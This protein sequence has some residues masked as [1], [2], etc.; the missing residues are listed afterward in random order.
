MSKIDRK[1]RCTHRQGAALLVVLFIVMAIAILSLGFL[2]A[3]DVELTCG[4][5]MILRA[6]MDCLAESGLE[7][8][9][10][11]I[12][13][14]QEI[15]SEYWTGTTG[16]QLVAGSDDYYDITVT[17][18]G[19]LNYQITS[20]A[21]REKGGQEL[22]RSNL[23]AEL[24]LDPCIA[25]RTGSQWTTE[26]GTVINGDVYS[27]GNLLG[28]GDINGDAFAGGYI[29]ADD[30]EGREHEYVADSDAPVSFPDLSTSDFEPQYYIGSNT[31]SPGTIATETLDNVTLGPTG[32]NPAGVYYRD[33]QLEL[34]NNVVVTG[35]LVVRDDLK[36]KGTGNSITAVKNFPA[37]IVGRELEM[38]NDA[39]LTITGLVQIKDEVKHTGI[40][41]GARLN[42]S[43]AL[44]IKDF[45]I[46]AFESSNDV[47]VITAVP[48][49]AAIEIWPELGTAQRWSPAAGAFFKSIQRQ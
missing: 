13:N 17:K 23:T 16:L 33:G 15:S 12:L 4:E 22:G 30:V 26:S 7:H 32:G 47:I 3:S 21:Y 19:E 41:N 31:Y 5:N 18:L 35:T 40:F 6:Q 14:P 49:K 38:D 11:L 20:S 44:F 48:N 8:A 43:G 10:G 24:R 28:V 39:Q 29:S 36:I 37:V 25:M 2:S 45:D 42:I 27:R 46:N 34:D 9:K 1:I